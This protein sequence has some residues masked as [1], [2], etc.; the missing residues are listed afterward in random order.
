MYETEKTGYLEEDFRLFHL[1]DQIKKNIP[2]II[3]IFIKS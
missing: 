3:M 1:K 2:I